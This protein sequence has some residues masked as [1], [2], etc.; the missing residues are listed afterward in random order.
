MSIV[1]KNKI[2]QNTMDLK[3]VASYNDK[4]MMEKYLEDNTP[5]HKDFDL[6]FEV[7]IK[8]KNINLLTVF[9]THQSSI[10]CN[11]LLKCFMSNDERIIDLF[12][13]SEKLYT[14]RFYIRYN[15]MSLLHD[16]MLVESW[17]VPAEI[18]KKEMFFY[19][20]DEMKIEV[21]LG[22][23]KWIFILDKKYQLGLLFY[24]FNLKT[25]SN[26]CL[27]SLSKTKIFRYFKEPGKD[28]MYKLKVF[29]NDK[30]AGYLSFYSI[31]KECFGSF[32]DKM[33][34]LEAKPLQFHFLNKA[35][36]SIQENRES[37]CYNLLRIPANANIEVEKRYFSNNVTHV[38]E[39]SSV[40]A[41]SMNEGIVLMSP[42]KSPKELVSNYLATQIVFLY[43]RRFEHVVSGFMEK[44]SLSS[45]KISKSFIKGLKQI[46]KDMNLSNYYVGVPISQYSEIQEVYNLTKLNSGLN[47]VAVKEAFN[48]AAILLMEEAE[49]V[50]NERERKIGLILGVLGITGFIS[51][52]FDYL[53]ISKNQKFIDTL[54]FP[55]N[56]LPFFLFLITFI[57][58]WKFLNKSES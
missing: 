28:K 21:E 38:Y 44:H 35:S 3:T 39:N 12:L 11:V 26:N 48:E 40:Y 19:I 32:C 58:I 4:D 22:S 14:E 34:F 1:L 6:A 47:Y 29:G 53:L 16:I 31:F 37:N 50:S 2:N 9:L 27:E 52:V 41:F 43:H 57:L 20:D 42:Y 25:R 13:S 33:K 5:S 46:R 30:V 51:F 17:K 18:K 55:F 54:D 7:A 49:E 8:N 15:F 56:T 36:F 23:I 10:C 45:S 24:V